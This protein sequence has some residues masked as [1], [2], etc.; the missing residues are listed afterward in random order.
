[1]L[2]SLV[3]AVPMFL[4]ISASSDTPALTVWLVELLEDEIEVVSVVLAVV[5]VVVV[6]TTEA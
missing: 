4:I 1:V 5:L 3:E 2:D 6:S